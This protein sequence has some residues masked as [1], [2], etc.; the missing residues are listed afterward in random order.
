MH[1]PILVSR[2]GGMSK[3]YHT[4]IHQPTSLLQLALRH[5]GVVCLHPLGGG[6]GR[7]RSLRDVSLRVSKHAHYRA[8]LIRMETLFRIFLDLFGFFCSQYDAVEFLL[9]ASCALYHPEALGTRPS[10]VQHQEGA[11]E[12][13]VG[14]QGLDARPE[15]LQHSDQ[16][17][18][19]VRAEADAI[20]E[21]GAQDLAKLLLRQLL[22]EVL[23]IENVLVFQRVEFL[24]SWIQTVTTY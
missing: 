8:I 2:V 24:Q 4:N 16:S 9:R 12:V 14:G 18:E 15:V 1:Y 13:A 21:E 22:P 10:V 3:V 19:E 20:A 11:G 7:G 17:G 23:V 5:K 6:G